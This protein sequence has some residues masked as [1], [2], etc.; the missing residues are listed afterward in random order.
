MPG[1]SLLVIALDLLRTALSL[2][3]GYLVGSLPVSAWVVRAAGVEGTRQSEGHSGPTNVWR[4]AGPGWGVLALTGDLAKGVLPVAIGIV[5]FTWWTGWVAGVGVLIG[6]GW[7]AVGRLAGGRGVATF[8]GVALA[9][10][11]LAGAVSLMLTLP[12][13]VA[14]RLLG[15]AGASRPSPPGSARSRCCSSPSNAT[16]RGCWA[17]GCCT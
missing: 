1:S 11:P 5:T 10:A 13:A 17:S 15:R 7:P 14:A 16:S 9:L 4:L 6:A 2:L 8:A 3:V 12:V